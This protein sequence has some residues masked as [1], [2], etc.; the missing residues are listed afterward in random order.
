MGSSMVSAPMFQD[1]FE[2]FPLNLALRCLTT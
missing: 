1:I 2:A